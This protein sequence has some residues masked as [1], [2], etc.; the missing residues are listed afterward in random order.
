M[1]II[2]LY[3][4][5]GGSSFYTFLEKVKDRI[6]KMAAIKKLFEAKE[7]APSTSD[8][9]QGLRQTEDMLA[10]KQDYL[11]KKIKTEE[12]IIRKNV[13][14]NKKLALT[15]LKRKKRFE[16]ELQRNDGTLNTLEQVQ[17]YSIIDNF[18]G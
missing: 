18:H 10:K 1:Y 6:K 3:L 17:K 14:S 8:A 12:D 9:I 7:K 2:R 15:A 4:L 5:N 16:A 11:E 13:K